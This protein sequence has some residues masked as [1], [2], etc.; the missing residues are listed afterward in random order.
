[1]IHM[2]LYQLKNIM[3]TMSELGAA[4]YAKRIA[5]AK[6]AIS[7]R[8]AYRLFGE[9]KVKSWVETGLVSAIRSGTTIRSKKLYSR[10]ELITAD[11][12]EKM[13]GILNN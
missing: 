9:A 12:S 4:N 3:H 5:P 6:D 10:E 7:Q 11:K 2:E 1:M 8:E 13:I